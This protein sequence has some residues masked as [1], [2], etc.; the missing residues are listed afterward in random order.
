MTPLLTGWGRTAP[1]AAR[2]VETSATGVPG[3]VRDH[4]ARGLIAR[5]LGRSYG[6]ASLPAAAGAR[7]AGSRLANRVIAFDPDTGILRAEAGLALHD[8]N[9]VSYTHLT[10]PTILRV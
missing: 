3:L 9:P 2:L 6:D 10:L 1:S 7:V 5:G 8:V 4:P